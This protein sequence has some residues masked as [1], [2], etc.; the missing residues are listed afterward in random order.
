MWAFYDPERGEWGYYTENGEFGTWHRL[1]G[2]PAHAA[3]IGDDWT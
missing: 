1:E 2:N 3:E